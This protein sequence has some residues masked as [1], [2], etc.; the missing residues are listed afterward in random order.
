[1][2][3]EEIDKILKDAA[4]QH[5]PPYD[6][7]AWGKMEI[8]LD[9][10]LPEKKDRKKPI[11]FLLL[12]LLL[13]GAI[14]W[15]IESAQKNSTAAVAEKIS[16]KYI[17][18]GTAS[19]SPATKNNGNAAIVSTPAD[20]NNTANNQSAPASGTGSLNNA[21]ANTTTNDDVDV[22]T[23]SKSKNYTNRGRTAMKVK[24]PVASSSSDDNLPTSKNTI[25]KNDDNNIVNPTA[26]NTKDVVDNNKMVTSQEDVT[27]KKT[28]YTP[29][30]KEK[31]P[32]E[33]SNT[34]A[35]SSKQKKNNKAVENKFAI[36][37]SGGADLSYITI[38][39]AGKIKPIYGAGVRY[40]VG[41]HIAISS[42]F[43]VSKKVYTALPTQYKFTGYT[44]PNLVKINADCN[45]YEIPLTVYYNFLQ[46]KKHGW[47]AG[48]GLSS[49]LMKK[50][51][52]EY[53]YQNPSGQPYSYD[54]TVSNENKHFLSVLS[55]SAGYQYKLSNRISFMAE[56][57]LK[58]PLSGIGLGKIKLNSTGVMLTAA[59][60]PFSKKK[61]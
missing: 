60:K 56:P 30:E 9:K 2:P 29:I 19:N 27:A 23:N 45:V 13:G 22:Y 11:F 33:K 36:T 31:T 41:K 14:F 25:T 16:G 21:A 8:L 52:Y 3:D 51:Y 44:N 26:D 61:K 40:A 46:A 54:K 38:N 6:D 59:I 34:T 28:D 53:D 10:H 43:N 32:V 57:Y 15:G 50:E 20:Q 24:S 1:M 18:A 49:F 5:H 12:F 58:V 48:V 17:E 7:T 4:N 55:L 37:V 42:G 35:A 47:F 39:N